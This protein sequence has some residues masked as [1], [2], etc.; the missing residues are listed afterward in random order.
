MSAHSE[1]SDRSTMAPPADTANL[2]VQLSEM[3][4]KFNELSVEISTQRRM[5]DQLVASSGGIQH[6]PM[7][8]SQSEIEHQPPPLSH[9]Q[10]TFEPSFVN[11]PEETFTYPD[12]SFPYTY[13]HNIQVNPT[14]IQ[15]PQ[16]CPDSQVPHHTTIEPF[17][18]DAAMQ[19]KVET[20][21][22]STP[23]DKNLLKR[24]DKFDEFMRKSQGLSKSGG[25]DFDELCLFP[26]VQLPL[27]FK[28]PKFSKYDGTGNPKTH[29]RL[30]ANKLGKPIDDENLPIRLFPESLEGDALN[31]YSNI[32]PEEMRT[33]LDLSTVFVRQYEYN[34][35]L[36]STRTTFEGTKRKPSEDHK[37]YAKR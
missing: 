23:I 6:D 10:V 36:A 31:W 28:I 30:F 1:S 12:S 14:S 27:G 17:M 35:E 7:P 34:C 15:M 37:T 32:K 4:N 21:E 18:L 33:W 3:L 20:G 29:L 16:N 22:S 19:G 2:G 13:P 5:I 25:L 8:I 9:T 11:I 26:N 24:L